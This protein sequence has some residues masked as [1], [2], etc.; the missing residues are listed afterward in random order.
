MDGFAVFDMV[1]I[2]VS[3]ESGQIIRFSQADCHML[4]GMEHIS[5][6][7]ASCRKAVDDYA[8]DYANKLAVNGKRYN[9]EIAADYF[10]KLKDGSYGII[11]YVY[12]KQSDG[13][14][15]TDNYSMAIKLFVELE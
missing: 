5:Y 7:M 1:K 4:D 6:D 13:N 14:Y 10:A 8:A 11:Y 3:S 9:Y 2:S 15:A 12:F